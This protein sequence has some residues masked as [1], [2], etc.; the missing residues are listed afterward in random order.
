[1]R[2]AN[3]CKRIA[4]EG[5][6]HIVATA[7]RDVNDAAAAT[8]TSLTVILY[9]SQHPPRLC[10][11]FPADAAAATANPLEY[12]FPH[13]MPVVDWAGTLS[14]LNSST[15]H[16]PVPTRSE[17]H[18]KGVWPTLAQLRH[19]TR[20]L[21]APTSPADRWRAVSDAALGGAVA[22]AAC[23]SLAHVAAHAPA[24]LDEYLVDHVLVAL[25]WLKS[26]PA[27]LKLNNQYARFLGDL[28]TWVV[29]GWHL[30]AVGPIARFLF[31]TLH[32]D[33][34]T[35]Y[36][37]AGMTGAIAGFPVMVAAALD[38]WRV[39]T[40]H[41]RVL[42]V[43]TARLGAWQA[44][45]CAA[46]L[47]LFLGKMQNPLR[48]RVDAG[49][50]A[51]DQLLMGT[52]LLTVLV[53]LFPTVAAYWAFFGAAHFVV[54]GPD[55]VARAIIAHPLP[56]AVVARYLWNPAQFPGRTRLVW[57]AARG[58]FVVKSEQ[59][60]LLRVLYDEPKLSSCT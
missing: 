23:V 12:H 29:Q 30:V 35:A 45:T 55:V 47:S 58:A 9:D 1:M 17:T 7:L 49:E 15:A 21:T 33:S 13:A 51:A 60:R 43:A 19:R 8:S 26:W 11:Q 42:Y 40:A 36:T 38:A 2:R 20:L 48:G 37:T 10:S 39:L 16:P 3:R 54:A 32:A 5:S 4:L 59:K 46:L 24:M 18:D 53:F 50:F 34:T 57:D 56:V 6:C 14:F 25:G 52:L 28:C 27:G 44:R 31:F 41:I 22:V